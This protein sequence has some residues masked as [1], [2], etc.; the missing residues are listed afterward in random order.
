MKKSEI[1]QLIIIILGVLIIYRI[2]INLV[3]QINMFIQFSGDFSDELTWIIITFVLVI[4]IAFAG[5]FII[6]KSKNISR[7]I[8]KDN[9]DDQLKVALNKSD[10]IHLSVIAISLYFL[11]QLF[12]SFVGALYSFIINFINDFTMF[13]ESYPQYIASILLYVIIF[14]VLVNSKQFSGW[15]EKK[16]L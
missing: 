3:T 11:V 8:V 5:I 1:V 2:V 15:L 13:L 7:K 4:L 12:P 6:Y 10:I 14:I 16:L 9:P